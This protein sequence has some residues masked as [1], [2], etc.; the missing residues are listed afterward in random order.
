MSCDCGCNGQLPCGCCE[1]TQILTPVKLGN[2]PGLNA[3]SYRAGTHGSFLTT[4]KARL[5]G[6]SQSPLAK[7]KTRDTGDFSI[8]LMDCW[9]TVGD[10]LTFY[11]ERVA[12]EG[13]LRT[14]GERRSV[15]ELA[16]LVGY[17]LRPG[18]AASTY[19]AYALDKPI[20][21]PALIDVN[22]VSTAPPDPPVTIP[23]GSKAQSVPGPGELPQ[24]FETSDDLIARAS[25]NNLQVRV[26]RPQK[27]TEST[28]TIYFKGNPN[29]KAGDP[30]LLL[31]YSSPAK[32]YL[33]RVESVTP[34][35]VK[36]RTRVTV[37]PWLRN[38]DDDDPDASTG[39]SFQQVVK[40][41]IVR[42]SAVENFGVS[43]TSRSGADTLRILEQLKSQLA[44]TTD[45]ATLAAFMRRQ[46]LPKLKEQHDAAVTGRFTRVEPWLSALIEALESAV[47][48]EMATHAGREGGLGAAPLPKP[49]GVTTLG[50]VLST[51]TKA[52]SIQPQ[53]ELELSRSVTSSLSA[54]GDL[55]ARLLSELKPELGPVLYKAWSNVP[56]STSPN[57][58]VHTL[59]TRA[60]LFGHNAPP[61]PVKNDE[62]VVTGTKEWDLHY[63]STTSTEPFRIDMRSDQGHQQ[64]TGVITVG[65]HPSEQQTFNIGENTVEITAA[66]EKVLVDVKRVTDTVFVIRFEF[67]T[68]PIVLSVGL[69]FGQSNLS[70]DSSES[71]T[72]VSVSESTL[73]TAGSMT[74]R[75][76]LQTTAGRQSKE[77]ANVVWLDAAYDRL[78]PDSHDDDDRSSPDTQSWIVLER[79]EAVI[80]PDGT[81][82]IPKLVISRVVQVGERSRSDYGIALKSTR[83]TLDK[84]W[85]DVRASDD[86]EVVRGTAVFAESERLELAEEPIED[87]IAGAELELAGLYEGLESGKWL[88]VSGERTDVGASDSQ[89]SGQQPATRVA[90]VPAT[91][92]VMLAGISQRYDANLPGDKTHSFLGLANALAY[93]YKRDTVVV[94]GNVVH[95]THG[96]TRQEVLGSGDAA[97][98]LQQFTLK[99]YPLTFI[100]A[101]T[102]A[103]AETTLQV[104]V[105]D[106][107]WSETDTL[108]ALGANDHRYITRTD[109]D[110][111]TSIVFGTGQNG[112]RLPTGPENITAKYRTGIGKPGNVRSD[113]ITLLTSRPL[114]VK[115]VTNPLPGTGGADREDRDQARRNTPLAVTSLDRLVSTQDYADFARTFAGV[116]KA[117]ATRLSDGQRRVVHLTI[118]GDDDIQ[119][120]PTSDLYRNLIKALRDFG[121]PFVPVQ[122]VMRSLRL[123]LVEA[124][125]RVRPEY[126]WEKVEPKIR[127]AML[128]HFSFKNRELGQDVLLSDVI[129]TIHRVE[130]V[131]YT[132]VNQFDSVDAEGIVSQL[133][134]GDALS[135]AL[136]LRE[137][138]PVDLAR[139]DFTETDASK[140]I[141]PAELVYL[142]P[143][144]A[145]TL[146]LSEITS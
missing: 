58:E 125:V 69:T 96:E 142:T 134:G 33:F 74:I 23:A 130:G 68:R 128:D 44:S 100:S 24:T 76:Q 119:I 140:R 48:N 117:S 54:N 137:R 1:G 47:K 19:L 78:K 31:I 8:A 83:I 53:S 64:F 25:W 21:I 126:L 40:A 145:D 107:L 108:A 34:D 112:S 60:S 70:V 132:D 121:D 133:S 57:F 84:P 39:A 116:A 12:N 139:I 109:D 131:A 49:K 55:A 16:R 46:T 41:I 36:E 28:R 89:T 4:M 94:Y 50:A 43:A 98:S 127:A 97:K 88:I 61:E 62:G 29:L 81:T 38:V 90:G 146:V 105:N 18:V 138:I 99:Q 115:G 22:A 71:G 124:A 51:L 65:S 27:I 11:Q 30:L 110:D 52:P 75:G 87:D 86:F 63:F 85:I 104:R 59:R 17:V 79:P 91:E 111:K 6:N 77:A 82:F 35:P 93:T 73:T 66:E 141:R 13:F 14:A 118:A 103:G 129:S 144:V 120:Q 7:L 123:L 92:L 67:S 143:D 32:P 72:G 20:A 9:A 56:V 2:R 37:S 106:V 80:D 101:A 45:E 114:G 5:A 26:T 122:L 42:F 15:L 3:I 102:P 10:V 113:Q 135:D 95:A 136:K